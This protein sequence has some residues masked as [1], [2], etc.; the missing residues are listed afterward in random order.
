MYTRVSPTG[1]VRYVPE[2]CWSGLTLIPTIARSSNARGAVLYDMNGRMVQRWEGLYGAFDNKLLPGGDIFGTTRYTPGYWLDCENLVQMDWNGKIKWSFNRSE[3]ITDNGVKIWSAR[4][5]HDFQRE[6][7]PVGY[8]SPGQE[9]KLS[10]KTLVNS[11]Q[12]R[13]L[14]DYSPHKLADTKL[15]EID[16]EG[17][18]LWSWSLFDHWDQLGQE[19]IAKLVH[20]DIPTFPGTDYVKMTYCNNINYLGPNRWYDA[21]DERFHPDNI[22]SDIRILNVSFIID[23]KSGDIVWR[24]GPDAEYSKELQDIGQIVGQ[25]HV[26]IIPK[27]LP[28]EGNILLFDN[29]G[30]AGL[31]KP[32]PCAPTGYYNATRGYS[33]VLEI[34]P[35][36]MKIVWAYNDANFNYGGNIEHL[37]IDNRL[38]SAYCCGADRLPNGNTLI[39]E[40]V[41]GRVIEVTPDSEIVWEFINPGGS[42]F[43]AHR[44]PHE[45]CPQVTKAPEVA[46][47]P[48]MNSRIRINEKGEPV[49]VPEDPFFM[50]RMLD[51]GE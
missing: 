8:Y 46:V 13:L 24:L 31:G 50:S 42:V 29:G 38:F 48:L 27:G 7:N 49:A 45:W 23:R 3:E 2:K 5:H 36:T 22:I 28:G 25:H 12:T 47:T 34:D 26:H 32:S 9:P 41:N 10:G 21:G 35:V 40:F 43:R 14:P 16:E 30:Q 51:E 1:V 4:Q 18:I 17:N 19:T 11:T 39:S 6:G 20:R 33:R 15:L 44:Y 37:C